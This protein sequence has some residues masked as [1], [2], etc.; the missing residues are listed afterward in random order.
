MLV[1]ILICLVLLYIGY[2]IYRHFYFVSVDNTLMLSGAPG[3]GKT[4]EGVKWALKLYRINKSKVRSKNR[5]IWFR[6]L[7]KKE[8]YDYL[9]M[10]RLYSDIP[11]RIGKWRRRKYNKLIEQLMIDTGLER[12]FLLNNVSRTKFCFRL[13][14]EHIMNQE[15]LAKRSVLFATE[16]GKLVSQY[17]WNNENVQV[18]VNDFIGMWRQY[19][20]GGYF[21]CDDQS[22]DNVAVQIRRR[23]GTV[24]NMLHFRKFWKIYWV[25]MRN[26]TISE[27]VKAVSDE[28]AEDSMRWKVGLFPLFHRNYDTYAYSKRYDSVPEGDDLIYTTYKTNELIKLPKTTITRVYGQ[29]HVSGLLDSKLDELDD[30]VLTVSEDFTRR[31]IL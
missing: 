16:L 7:F 31:F 14:G 25:K 19:S 21:V 15:R 8:K 13:K 9:E 20:E 24:I 26:L 5:K 28:S 2:K 12:S 22:T 10:P 29:N 30:F 11:I 3:T 18:H 17:D 6:N 23:I 1:F 4:N 27:E